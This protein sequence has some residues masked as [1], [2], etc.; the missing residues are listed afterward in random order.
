M[1]VDNSCSEVCVGP[2]LTSCSKKDTLLEQK[3]RTIHLL[4][5]RTI[6]F[7]LDRI[8]WVAIRDE[9]MAVRIE[10]EEVLT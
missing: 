1:A 7:A 9:N 4:Q 3:K 2:P 6:L 8:I 5:N 10:S